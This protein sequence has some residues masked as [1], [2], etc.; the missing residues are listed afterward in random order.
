MKAS[1]S[2]LPV[3]FEFCIAFPMTEIPLPLK[4]LPLAQC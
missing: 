2:A 4:I 1:S 3:P